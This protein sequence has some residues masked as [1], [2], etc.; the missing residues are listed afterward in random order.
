M[1]F[2]AYLIAQC[3]DGLAPFASQP[4]SFAA[5]RMIAGLA[6]SVVHC[7]PMCGPFVLGQ[8]AADAIPARGDYGEWRRLRGAALAPYHLGR[9]TTYTLLGALAGIAT[10]VFGQLPYLAWIGSALLVVAAALLFLQGLGL[11]VAG[12]HSALAGMLSR[13]AGPFATSSA[14]AHRY[15]FGVVLGFLPCGLL[16]GALAAAGATGSAAHGALAMAGFSLGTMPALVA[17]GWGGALLGR[18]LKD[19]MKLVANILLALNS[20]VLLGF[21]GVRLTSL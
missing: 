20:L 8:V 18:R 12:E 19:H 7:A 6:G 5:A 4:L 1:E 14:P 13:V 15:L 9:A 11:L 3:R 16:Y 2:V 10:S 17:V 21:A